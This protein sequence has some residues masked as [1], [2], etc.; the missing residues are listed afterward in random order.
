MIG[1]AR[2]A[3]S[4]VHD[5]AIGLEFKTGDMVEALAAEADFPADIVLWHGDRPGDRRH[6]VR[7]AL[8]AAGDRVIGDPPPPA[9]QA[10]AA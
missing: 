2:V 7:A 10:R 5:W 8:A 3:S 6:G 1:R 4:R 9:F